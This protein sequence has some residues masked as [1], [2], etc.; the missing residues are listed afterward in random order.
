G[1]LPYGPPIG[2]Q[3]PLPTEIGVAAEAARE[4]A[5]AWTAVALRKHSRKR[6][7]N[8]IPFYLHLALFYKYF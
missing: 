3:F 4:A 8:K 7:S 6:F 1:A 5:T 2:V